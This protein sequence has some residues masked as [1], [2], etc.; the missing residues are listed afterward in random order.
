MYIPKHF[1]ESN[2][3]VLHEFIRC[4]PFA[5][6]VTNIDSGLNADHIPVYLNTENINRVCLQGH[7]AASNPLWKNLSENQEALL[8][9]QGGNAYIT[10]S[11]FPSKKLNGKVVPTWNYSAVHVKGSI[12]FIHEPTWKIN[13]LNNLTAHQ[14]K[15]L[16]MP[17]QVSDAPLEYIEKLLPAIVGFEILVNEIFG[18]FKLSQNQSQENRIGIAEGLEKQGHEMAKR[19]SKTNF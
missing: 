13:L 10:P 15:K 5:I 17:W 7:I 8:I 11:W 19:I 2:I 14:E 18:K 4:N 9:F 6:L 16:E 3:N 1:E 12:E